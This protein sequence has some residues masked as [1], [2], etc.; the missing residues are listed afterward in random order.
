MLN[1]LLCVMCGSSRLYILISPFAY[2]PCIY[3]VRVRSYY[4][5]IYIYYNYSLWSFC[6]P[7][8]LFP[9]LRASLQQRLAIFFILAGLISRI[10]FSYY[11]IAAYILRALRFMIYMLDRYRS[12]LVHM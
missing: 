10:P 1:V 6:I 2:V 4:K 5:Q 8:Y 12:T 3:S 9:I 11:M 7:F